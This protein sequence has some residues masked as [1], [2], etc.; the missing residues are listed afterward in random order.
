MTSWGSL[1][2]SV[3]EEVYSNKTP[4][5]V[6]DTP[7]LHSSWRLGSRTVHSVSSSRCCSHSP[8]WDIGRRHPRP[9]LGGEGNCHSLLLAEW[10]RRSSSLELTFHCKRRRPLVETSG[11][12]IEVLRGDARVER[13]HCTEVE[14]TKEKKEKSETTKSDLE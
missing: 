5:E 3:V 13:G 9:G 10:T 14:N 7:H 1:P 2:V 6:Q 4:F 8:R 11:S 12:V